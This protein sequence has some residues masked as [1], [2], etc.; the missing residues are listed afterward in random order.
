MTRSTRMPAAFSRCCLAALLLA[1]AASA[2][3]QEQDRLVVGLGAAV[4]PGYQGSDDYITDPVPLIDYRKGRFFA[5]TSDG[6]GFTVLETGRFTVGA[7]VAWMRGYDGKDVPAG[8]GELKS[9]LGG[10]LFVSTRLG[11]ALATV[12]ATQALTK[13][14]RGMQVDARLAYPWQVD[15]R[16]TVAPAVSVSWA[17]DKY[18]GSYFGIDARR[19]AASGLPAYAPSAGIKD[20]ALRIG[21]NYR[22][23]QHW[24][25]A[26]AIGASRLMDAAAD[27][28]LVVRKTQPAAMLGLS[29]RF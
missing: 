19:A 10:R 14:E 1:A 22:F 13:S 9:A 26:G 17:N 15:E 20:V 3:A 5:R 24:S 27:S 21:V 7:S 11:G 12:S 2:A 29:Y 4:L 25:V 8:I 16:L 23:G 28:P 18:M 6:I